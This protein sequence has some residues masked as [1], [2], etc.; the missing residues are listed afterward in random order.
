MYCLFN[1]PDIIIYGIS[2]TNEK[3][4]HYIYLLNNISYDIYVL[5]YCT[6]VNH[7]YINKS[8]RVN[9]KLIRIDFDIE[10]FIKYTNYEKDKWKN[11]KNNIDKIK[12]LSDILN[13]CNNI[14]ENVVNT[15]KYYMTILNEYLTSENKIITCTI[16]H[17]PKFIEIMQNIINDNKINFDYNYFFDRFKILKQIMR[18]KY[19]YDIIT[20][21]NIYYYRGFWFDSNKK[22][23]I[24]LFKNDY[25]RIYHSYV[26]NGKYY[27]YDSYLKNYDI[28]SFETNI[29]SYKKTFISFDY[30][31]DFY[32]FGEF[33]DVCLRMLFSEKINADGGIFMDSHRISDMNYILEKFGYNTNDV[34]INKKGNVYHFDTVK[35]LQFSNYPC[36]GFIDNFMASSLSKKLNKCEI[37]DKCY[38][39]YLK[40]G[41]NGRNIV[42]EEILIKNLLE[43]NFIILDGTESL[44]DIQNY[45][46]NA[47]F[48]LY[49]HGSLVKNYIYCAKNPVVIELAPIT[50]THLPFTGNCLN[51]GFVT[52]IFVVKSD[53]NEKIII[54]E[55]YINNLVEFIDYFI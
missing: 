34:S 9:I 52:Q 15:Q 37:T 49:A 32:N 21:N 50:R 36:R 6:D 51:M 22:L 24:D 7:E 8:I 28:P 14:P 54:D 39:L 41:S 44:Y 29:I 2:I 12:N 13:N 5:I 16:I 30:I 23:L 18:T 10:L 42:N 11:K 47:T 17:K 33:W 45:F 55:N 1:Y 35:F 27:N 38:F 31:Y 43:R 40:R 53:E 25:E 3:L 4:Q 48:I 46:T 19:N 26:I 20:Y